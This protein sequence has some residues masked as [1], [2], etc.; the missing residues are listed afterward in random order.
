MLRK[1]GIKGLHELLHVCQERAIK[2]EGDNIVDNVDN[3]TELDISTRKTGELMD[4]IL[5]HIRY[6]AVQQFSGQVTV[7]VWLL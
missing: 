2:D 3:S 6:N 7:D 1:V 5:I 4:R